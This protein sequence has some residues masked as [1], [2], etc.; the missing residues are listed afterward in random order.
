MMPIHKFAILKDG[1]E[2]KTKHYMGLPPE[3]TNNIN[4][5]KILKVAKV[6]VVFDTVV[7][8]YELYRYD[9]NGEFAGDTWHETEDDATEQAK[10][11]F[12][13]KG[14]YWRHIPRDIDD[15]IK[16]AIEFMKSRKKSR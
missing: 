5:A 13:L 10:F 15:P 6:L 16:Y 3:V 1:I 11:E 4:K 12:N 9:K 2:S 7:N 8:G 14:I